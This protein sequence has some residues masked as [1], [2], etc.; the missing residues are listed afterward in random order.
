MKVTNICGMQCTV[1]KN[2]NVEESERVEGN[3]LSD[4]SIFHAM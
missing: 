4:G 3:A 1:K 2:C